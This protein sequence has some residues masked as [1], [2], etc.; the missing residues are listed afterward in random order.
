MYNTIYIYLILF[1][2]TLI[3]IEK[4]NALKDLQMFLLIQKAIDN[5]F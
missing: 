1:M 4:K 5:I 2:I 3:N